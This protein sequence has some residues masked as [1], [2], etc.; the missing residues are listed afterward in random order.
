MPTTP[1]LHD[2]LTGRGIRP[3]SLWLMLIGIPSLL[4]FWSIRKNDSTEAWILYVVTALVAGWS[5]PTTY[6]GNVIADIG[7]FR[8][9][10]V[11]I[12]PILPQIA[13]SLP[14]LIYVAYPVLPELLPQMGKIAP[15]LKHL[16]PHAEFLIRI[17]PKV[18]SRLDELIPLVE[19][20][21]PKFKEFTPEHLAN[22]ELILDDVIEK[23]DLLLPHIEALTPIL[24]EGIL[25]AP[26]MMPHIEKVLPHLAR[27]EKDLEWLIPFAEIE[28]VELMLPLLDKIA[29]RIG[30]LQPYAEALLPHMDKLKTLSPHLRS[31]NIDALLDTLPDAIEHIDPLLYWTGN[32]LPLASK[33]GVLRN[34]AFLTAAVPAI[35]KFLPPRPQERPSRARR[36]ILLK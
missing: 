25:V 15:N 36:I 30:E 32:F 16:L 18:S 6:F 7:R 10:I 29:P 35:V 20:V 9:S 1:V 3:Y 19:K 17:V 33:L 5:I 13:T 27:L 14:R 23:L 2:F 8:K 31:D 12:V 28:G 21:A 22:L 26:R 34:R 11:E 24:T 4:I